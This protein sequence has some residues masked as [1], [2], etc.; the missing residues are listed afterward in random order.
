MTR[1]VGWF[2]LWALPGTL[3]GAWLGARAYRRLSDHHFHRLVLCLLGFSGLT[4][5]WPGIFGG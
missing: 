4:L 1:E 2:V 5:V 3:A